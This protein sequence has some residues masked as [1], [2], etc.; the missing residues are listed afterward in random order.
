VPALW[1]KPVDATGR[2]LEPIG[3]VLAFGGQGRGR[4]GPASTAGLRIIP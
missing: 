4:G 3:G 2:R 1:S